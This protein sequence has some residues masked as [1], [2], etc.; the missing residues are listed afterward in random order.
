MKNKLFF[1]FSY[2]GLRQGNTNFT[3]AYVETPEYRQ[4]VIAARPGSIIAQVLN[5]PGIEPRVTRLHSHGVSRPDLPPEPAG[6]CPA[7]WIS[8]RSPARAASTSISAANPA[9]ARPRRHSRCHV[10]ANRAARPCARQPVQRPNRFQP[11]LRRFLRGQHLYF[12]AQPAATPMP[13]EDRRPMADLPFKP[14]NTAATVTYNRT[15]SA[16]MLNEA[17]VQLHPLFATTESPMPANVN[18]GIPRLEVEGLACPTAS[19]SARRRARP[20]RPN[21]RRTSS[22]CATA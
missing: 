13:L 15:L 14:L 7:A 3:T 21:S 10:R 16:T 6:R 11:D 17:P 2:E 5:S 12:D 18:F 1:F 20:R 4:Q 19:A 8:A 9:G 22:S